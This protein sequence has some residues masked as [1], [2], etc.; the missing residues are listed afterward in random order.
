MLEVSAD[1]GL[2]MLRSAPA[3]GL[4]AVADAAGMGAR[5]LMLEVERLQGR[6][7]CD[8]LAASAMTYPLITRAKKRR[9]L[10]HRVCPP[11][12]TLRYAWDISA[13]DRVP[14][15]V[16]WTHRLVDQPAAPRV[17]FATDA[18]ARVSGLYAVGRAH[19]PPAI[20]VRFAM[21]SG[22]RRAE[23]LAA[24]T[25]HLPVLAALVTSADEATRYAAAYRG[26]L[27]PALEAAALR[28]LEQH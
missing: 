8:K 25:P 2:R 26:D 19:C 11:F 27:P 20:A 5:D 23:R 17:A 13:C 14:G 15:V 1:I 12:V 3:M 10:D 21:V 24:V 7:R 9:I 22:P 6:R 28:T 18:A 4:A 16:G